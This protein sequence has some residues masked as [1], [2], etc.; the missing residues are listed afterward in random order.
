MY[1]SNSFRVSPIVIPAKAGIHNCRGHCLS[2]WI[3]ALAGMTGII[4]PCRFSLT[5]RQLNKNTK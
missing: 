2:D 1:I 5:Q 3:P 4:Q